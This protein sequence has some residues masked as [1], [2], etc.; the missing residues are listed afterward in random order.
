M[1]KISKAELLRALT[2]AEAGRPVSPGVARVPPLTS[3][4]LA[5]TR[6]ATE[7]ALRPV[8][9]KAGFNDRAFK[10]LRKQHGAELKRLAEREQ[11]TAVRRSPKIRKTLRAG[12]ANKI[13]AY[14]TL[15][16]L[17]ASPFL[18]IIDRPFLIWAKP[19]SNIIWD[20]HIGTGDSWAKIKAVGETGDKIWG[21]DTLSFYF[22]WDNPTPYYAVIDAAT[23]I[24]FNGFARAYADGSFWGGID[25]SYSHYSYLSMWT[26]LTL[27]QW[28]DN[29]PTPSGT[30]IQYIA[31]L[32]ANAGFFE[33]TQTAAISGSSDHSYTH[34][35]VNPNGVIVFEVSLAMSYSIYDGHTLSDFSDGSYE[36]SC[37]Y[38]VVG[39]LSTPPV[40]G[41]ATS[42]AI[43]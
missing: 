11:S 10:E 5:G 28:S 2:A 1:P 25:P 13:K 41:M 31:S 23:F 32:T 3:P 37:P 6:R 12:L 15:A 9:V 20:S 21:N 14:G 33:D 36:V 40:G 8:L 17:P 27:W 29:P 34:Y 24:T 38:M 22:L 18:T 42:A 7:A 4:K 26:G 19:R 43:A 30:P 35:V 39:L 16:N